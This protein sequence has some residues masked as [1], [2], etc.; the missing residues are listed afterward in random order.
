MSADAA[1]ISNRV[2]IGHSYWRQIVPSATEKLRPVQPQPFD[3]VAAQN[4][5]LSGANFPVIDFHTHL[6]GGLTLDEVLAHMRETGIGAGIEGFRQS[7]PKHAPCYIAL[8]CEGR[9]WPTLF[10]TEAIA[11]FDYVFTDAM[12]ISDHRGKRTRLWLKDEVDIPDKQA[13]MDSLVSQIVK[14]MDNEPIAIYVNATYLPDVISAEYDALWVSERMQKVINAAVR[15]NV[16]IEISARFKIPS[17]AFMNRTK[18]AGLNFTLGTNNPDKEMDRLE[19]SLQ[20][21]KECGLNWQD[22]WMPKPVG[23]KPA[24]VKVKR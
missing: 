11:K 24:Q 7:I 18:A 4:L 19:Y 8:Q 10:S 5:E 13:F 14:I 23:Q 2:G 21:V 16:A 17:A 6:K 1:V 3:R 9:E 15:N 12:T 22:M 20:M